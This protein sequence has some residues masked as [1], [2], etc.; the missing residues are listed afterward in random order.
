MLSMKL[1][2][3]VIALLLIVIAAVAYETLLPTNQSIMAPTR[4]QIQRSDQAAQSTLNN[5]LRYRPPPAGQVAN[6][7]PTSGKSQ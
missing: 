3:T 2:I 6:P 4:A 7:F 1:L 5:A